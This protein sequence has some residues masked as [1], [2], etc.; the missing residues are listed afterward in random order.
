MPPTFSLPLTVEGVRSLVANATS[1]NHQ[2]NMYLAYAAAGL[3]AAKQL[4]SAIGGGEQKAKKGRSKQLRRGSGAGGVAGGAAGAQ[5]HRS[6]SVIAAELSQ[7]HHQH[8]HANAA[9]AANGGT[10]P[11]LVSIDGA[12]E[13]SLRGLAPEGRTPPL[14]ASNAAGGSLNRTP[15]A[16]RAALG[17]HNRQRSFGDFRRAASTA[18]LDALAAAS[19][20][21][22]GR[23]AAMGMG[24]PKAMSAANLLREGGGGGGALS[25]GDEAE[26]EVNLT[27]PTTKEGPLMGA[28]GASVAKNTIS[29]GSGGGGAASMGDSQSSAG[30]FCD[31][32][33]GECEAP[34]PKKDGTYPG[35]WSDVAFL[36]KIGFRG[37]LKGKEVLLLFSYI[38]ILLLRT[39]ISTRTVFV[40]GEMLQAVI[41]KDKRA[42]VRALTI[43][44][45]M[46]I[47]NAII[48]TLMRYLNQSFALA[49]RTNINAYIS[50]KYFSS[51]AYYKIAPVGGRKNHVPNIDQAVTDDVA[52]WA[53]R[54]SNLLSFLGRPAFDMCFFSSMLF[55]NFG[56][57]NQFAG[58]AVSYETSKLLRYVRPNF[59]E[60]IQ[61]RGALEADF[62]S[63]HSKIVAGAEEIAFS[64]GEAR[65]RTVVQRCYDRLREYSERVFLQNFRYFCCEE[66]VTRYVWSSI[67]LLQVA[68]IAFRAQL[69]AAET[70]K[71]VVVMRRIMAKNGAATEKFMRGVK[72]IHEF[73]GVTSGL[74]Q[75]F[76]A[77]RSVE[78]AAAA[79]AERAELRTV[80]YCDPTDLA[81][82]DLVVATPSNEIL[83]KSL[84]FRLRR[85][86]RLLVLGPNGC[87][88]SS[89]F[90]VL[91]GLWPQRGGK[92]H[93]PR[94]PAAASS[95]GTPATCALCEDPSKVTSSSAVF[96][97]PQKPYVMRGTLREQ[98]HYPDPTPRAGMSDADL[99]EIVES[100]KLRYLVDHA[101]G[102][103]TV[104]D[105]GEILSGGEKQR[106]G[107]ARIFYHRPLYAVL[108]ECSS[109]INADAEQA[110]F[111]RLVGA[112]TTLIT[113]SHRQTLQQ[114]H[115]KLL[116]FDSEGGYRFEENGAEKGEE[117]T[118]LKGRR[119]ELRRELGSVLKNLGEDWPTGPTD[120]QEDD[121]MDDDDLVEEEEEEE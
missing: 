56:F 46:G 21:T 103:D 93:L 111:G 24:F 17:I 99:M 95:E 98:L 8:A 80:E 61:V 40:D 107:L 83:I 30:G 7:L 85:G 59:S 74:M 23:G 116:I 15:S 97:L 78:A 55:Q 113:I 115:N 75:V 37:T 67:G 70:A 16:K 91:C 11:P 110:I 112:G 62:R 90:R 54:L 88:K 92:I 105:W 10:T 69:P 121:D 34:A 104:E 86:D 53:G 33:G 5:R 25:D 52:L 6:D 12:G 41:A 94:P 27:S 35:F 29:G 87:G 114:F 9:V 89:L 66:Y 73:A 84:T 82:E 22:H 109:A 117:L 57:W 32:E 47:P 3:Y 63:A 81:V 39:I 68:F 100:V 102:L 118:A 106:I 72:Q 19:S 38:S 4:S 26:A 51:R 43:W 18:G 14:S 60:A 1:D 49:L 50:K 28:M 64:N 48:N 96:F 45:L 36:V 42:L 79:A 76:A 58:M 120:A 20:P 44:L 101:G 31:A 2:W 65:E 13:G 119:E 77:L 71:R 108:D